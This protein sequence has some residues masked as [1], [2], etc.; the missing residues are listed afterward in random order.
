MLEKLPGA[1]GHVLRHRRAG[2]DK[3]AFHHSGLRAGLAAIQVSSLA[4]ADHM[5]IPARYTADGEGLSP[6]LQWQGVPAGTA[7][8][9]LIVEDADAPT[10]QPLV[11][12]IVVD[13][14]PEDGALAEGALQSADHEGTADVHEGRNSYFRAGWLPPDPPPGH[15]SHRY[16]FQLFALGP[17]APFS[18]TPGRD[19]VM[20]EVRARAL[21]SGLLIGT[22]ARPDG[23]IKAGEG[24]KAA[25]VTAAVPPH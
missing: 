4:F 12:A 6:P 9:V 19:A 17:G 14:A 3:I 21:A 11:H 1:V 20:D 23:S 22:Y 2:L 15:G 5:P 10:P 18:G 13:L 16:A 7:S 8:L 25:A 24:A